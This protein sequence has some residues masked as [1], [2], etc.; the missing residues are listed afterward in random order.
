M[1]A[2]IAALLLLICAPGAT[3]EKGVQGPSSGH[4]PALTPV[5]SAREP[6]PT[7][8]TSNRAYL[9]Y[10]KNTAEFIDNV[11]VKDASGDLWAD[12]MVVH[13]DR[14][15]REIKELIA[16]G[17]KVI[18]RAHK[19][20]SQSRKAVYTSSD[21]RIVLT[22]TP[23]I[24]EGRNTYTADKI[25]IFKDSEKTIFEP[26]ARLTFYSDRSPGELEEVP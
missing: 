18:T 26:T 10:D 7:V 1:S 6:Q 11:H 12:N 14:N 15:T 17:K 13:F 16:T 5:V 4:P 20:R 8:V 19:K 24:T 25:T 9:D 22:G 2:I 23:S 21:G 3:G